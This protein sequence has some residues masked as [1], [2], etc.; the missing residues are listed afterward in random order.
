MALSLLEEKIDDVE[1]EIERG[2]HGDVAKPGS[3]RRS[4]NSQAVQVALVWNQPRDRFVAVENSNGL[5]PAHVPEIL[6]Q[7]G[8][9]LRDLHA[10]HN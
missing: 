3:R 10:R 8:L 7:P 2:R 6:A 4:S 9:E 5:P 1:T